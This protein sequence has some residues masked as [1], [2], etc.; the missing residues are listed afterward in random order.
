MGKVRDS[1]FAAFDFRLPDYGCVVLIEKLYGGAN[2]QQD[3]TESKADDVPPVDLRHEE[4]V[5]EVVAANKKLRRTEIPRNLHPRDPVVE[6]LEAGLGRVLVGEHDE[7]S[8]CLAA[9]DLLRDVNNTAAK[10]SSR[11][12]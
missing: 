8:G 3:L 5:L 1:A 9:V 6:R 11:C 7:V 10:I 4:E 12:L 2:Q